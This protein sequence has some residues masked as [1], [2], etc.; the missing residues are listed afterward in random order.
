[1]TV[2]VASVVRSNVTEEV[3]VVGN[4]IGAATVEVVSRVAGRLD[5]VNVQLGDRVSRGETIA[6]VE[7]NEIRQ[8]VAQA[9]AAYAVSQATVK[10]READ[11]KYALTN[12]ERSRSLFGRHLLP[13]QTLDDAEARYQAAQ[14]QVELAGAQFNQ[15]SARLEELRITLANTRIPSP[16]DG[17]VGKR[18]VDAGAYVSANLPVASLVD[19]RSVRLVVNLVE[20][21]LRRVTVGAAAQADVDAFP[22]EVFKGRVARVAPVL[23]PATRTAEIEIEIPNPDYRLKPGMYAR[24]RLRVGQRDNTIVVPRNAIATVEGQRGVFVVD[25]GQDGT[26]VKFAKVQTGIENPDLSEVLDGVAEGQQVVTTGANALRDGDRVRLPGQSGGER[27]QRAQGPGGGSGAAG[28]EGRGATPEAGAGA[29]GRPRNPD[30]GD[31]GTGRG[32]PAAGPDGAPGGRN[33]PGGRGEL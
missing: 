27:G 23:D 17:F 33:R 26:S 2:E 14:A 4:L 25:K 29:S 5:S 24:V 6:K 28:G 11:L 9:E 10:Q 3:T 13:Q 30:G 8:Q 16:V 19:I 22:S 1:M 18:H 31:A 20:R 32:R 15:S 21:D 7:D 12:L